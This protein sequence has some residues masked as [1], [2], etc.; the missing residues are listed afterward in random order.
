[1]VAIDDPVTIR[2][3]RFAEWIEQRSSLYAFSLG[4]DKVT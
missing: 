3:R 2:D 1:L 4:K